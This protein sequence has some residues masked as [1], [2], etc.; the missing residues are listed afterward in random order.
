VFLPAEPIQVDFVPEES[1][2]SLARENTKNYA[3]SAGYEA[4]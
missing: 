4:V 1:S 2:S 3:I